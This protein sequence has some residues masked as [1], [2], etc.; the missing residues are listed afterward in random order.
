MKN[1]RETFEELVAES[2]ELIP[3]D[4]RALVDNLQIIIEDHPSRET[5]ADLGM[6]RNDVLYGLYQGTPLTSRTVDYTELPD[7]I[8]IYQGPLTEDFTDPEELRYEVART[9]IHELAHHFGI[10]E[11]RLEELGWD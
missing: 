4:L 8:I 6:T 2:L 7:R 5:L 11:D 10:D 9:V 1:S 3:P